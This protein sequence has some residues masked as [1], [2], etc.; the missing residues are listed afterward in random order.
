MIEFKLEEA[1]E[2]WAG[3]TIPDNL[4]IALQTSNTCHQ[5]E[6]S[7]RELLELYRVILY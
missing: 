4:E 7:L 2:S 3:T 6:A 1:W 5:M